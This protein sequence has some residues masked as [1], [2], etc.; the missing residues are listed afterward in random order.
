MRSWRILVVV[1]GLLLLPAICSAQQTLR[2]KFAQGQHLVVDCTQQT[3]VETSVNNKPRRAF[4]EMTMRLEWQV[5]SVDEQGVASIAQ[6][7]TRM[8]LKSTAP[9]AEPVVYDSDSTSKP[10]GTAREVATGIAPLIGAK[11]VVK[12]DP[13]GE[14][15]DITLSDETQQAIDKLP[16]NSQLKPLLTKEGLTNLFRL[17]EGQ[18]PENP[19]SAGDTWPADSETKT[20][21]GLLKQQGTYTYSGQQAVGEKQLEKVELKATAKLAAAADAPIKL[22]GQEQTKT[23]TLLFDREAG[24]VV[25]SEMRLI[26]KSIR[27]FRDT[28][29][30][31]RITST[32]KL[33]IAPK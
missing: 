22:Q 10:V 33:E 30:H 16:E 18:L 25:S 8:Q 19:V 5:E 13:R 4:L 15:T 23:G 9:D 7:F 27:P 26:S 24:R 21:Y 2:W 31:I 3:E 32:T 12:M 20:P 6:S 11:F 14:V 17:G 28:Q 1:L 29:I